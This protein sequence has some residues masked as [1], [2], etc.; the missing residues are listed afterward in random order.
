MRS[1]WGSSSMK[2]QWWETEQNRPDANVEPLKTRV[3]ISL[4]IICCFEF[5]LK[6]CW[7]VGQQ[8]IRAIFQV[9]SRTGAQGTSHFFSLQWWWLWR[10]MWQGRGE[11][12]RHFTVFLQQRRCFD[13]IR[14]FFSCCGLA[15]CDIEMCRVLFD[16]SDRQQCFCPP[17]QS[18]QGSSFFFSGSH[19]KCFVCHEYAQVMVIACCDSRVCPT[20]LMGLEPGE[21]F[22]MRNVANLIPP[23]E[24]EVL[25]QDSVLYNFCSTMFKDV[26]TSFSFTAMNYIH[27]LCLPMPYLPFVPHFVTLFPLHPLPDDLHYLRSRFLITMLL[28]YCTER[29]RFHCL[30]CLSVQGRYHGTS[31]ALEFA[32]TVLQVWL[33]PCIMCLAFLFLIPL[34]LGYHLLQAVVIIVL[35]LSMSV[36]K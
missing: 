17:P 14:V 30:N 1:D 16:S 20:L 28:S 15:H 8:R 10:I 35:L 33:V 22:T 31:A 4:A 21:V 19:P 34:C 3:C 12:S 6:C 18:F 13:Q 5:S 32:V 24:R 23:Y 36:D 27:R 2:Q 26:K 29:S 7:I 9:G 25:S 11:S